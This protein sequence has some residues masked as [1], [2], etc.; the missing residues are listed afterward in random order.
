M[1]KPSIFAVTLVACLVGRAAVV[2][3][4]PSPPPLRIQT[5]SAI[6]DAGL[7]ALDHGD[8][9]MAVGLFELAAAL[10]PHPVLDYDQ[11]QAHRLA[12]RATSAIAAYQ[13]ALAT[14][15]S[16]PEA[17]QARGYIDAL[18]AS[19]PV[20][21]A[22]AVVPPP[23]PSPVRVAPI[24]RA[25]RGRGLRIAGITAGAVGVAAAGVGVYFFLDSRAIA[26]ELSTPGTPYLPARDAAGR[27]AGRYALIGSAV[28][29]AL[30]AGGLGLYVL[31]HRARSRGERVVLVP[32]LDG[33]SVG[34]AVVGGLP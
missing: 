19:L 17:D 16:G 8:Y 26:R 28:G 2:V 32:Q 33:H 6:V 13:R 25:G 15:L 1:T 29:G 22:P 27:R 31:G 21:S 14:G 10:S 23:P 5:A 11:G 7:A 3:A 18:T 24:R 4:Q 9:D 34:L 30:L 20:T 12:G